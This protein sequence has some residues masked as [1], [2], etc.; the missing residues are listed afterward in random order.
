MTDD[1]RDDESRVVICFGAAPASMAALQTAV[2]VA[3][4]FR[5]EIE[6]IFVEDEQLFSLAS[7]PFAR[8]VSLISR[9][10]RP[11]TPDTLAREIRAM[12]NAM[13]RRVEELAARASVPFRFREASTRLDE[14]IAQWQEVG[15]RFLAF[16]EPLEPPRIPEFHRIFINHTRLAGVIITGPTARRYQGPVVAIVEDSESAQRVIATA[17]K[18]AEASSVPLILVPSSPAGALMSAIEAAEREVGLSAATRI[19]NATLRDVDSAAQVLRRIG[20]G[21]IVA[22]LGGEILPDETA[23]QRLAAAA[24]SPILLLPRGRKKRAG[25]PD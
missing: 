19:E 16:A 25:S 22:E 21:L 8:E 6:A 13:R 12:A 2:T 24:E 14:I 15:R 18:L 3:R 7:L 20:G 11:L 5:G 4:A 17:A 23:L 1:V 9:R 10:S